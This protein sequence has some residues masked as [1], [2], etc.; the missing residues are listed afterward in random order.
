LAFAQVARVSDFGK[1]DTMFI[2]RTHLGHLLNAG[3][4]ALGYDL[5]GANLY[6][7]DMD[8]ATTR[9]N[10]PEVILVKKSYEKKPCTRRWKLKRLPVEEDV[11][12]KA[13]GEEEKKRDEHEAFLEVLEQNPE[14]RFNINLYM[15]EDYRSEMASTTGDD[16]PTVP[17]EELIEDLTPGDDD[18]AVE[19]NTHAGM[20]E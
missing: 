4:L 19:R 9:H 3:D 14:L 13:K 17:I 8:T 20:V 7:E 10:L 2:V 12:N 5:Y 6:D 15:N 16:A 1:N 11:G 18:E